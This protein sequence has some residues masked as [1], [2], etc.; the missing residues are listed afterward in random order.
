MPLSLKASSHNSPPDNLRLIR[1]DLHQRPD[2]DL[3]Q[4]EMPEW[5][6]LCG[7]GFMSFILMVGNPQSLFYFLRLFCFSLDIALVIGFQQD[8]SPGLQCNFLKV[9]QPMFSITITYAIRF[10]Y[11]LVSIITDLHLFTPS[12]LELQQ[13]LKHGDQ[14]ILATFWYRNCLQMQSSFINLRFNKYL[15]NSGVS[16]NGNINALNS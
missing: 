1:A 16:P 7:S 5:L 9:V 6:M 14:V 12:L 13:L 10:G 15:T 11:K 4:V 2:P 8:L 3:R